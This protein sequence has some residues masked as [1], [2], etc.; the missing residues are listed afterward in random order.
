M[1]PGSRILSTVPDNWYAIMS[2]TSMATPFAV[3]VAALYLSYVRNNN[4]NIKLENNLDYVKVFKEHTLSIKN[5]DI[6]DK[7]FYQGFGILDPK[8]LF[9]SLKSVFFELFF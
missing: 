9:E 6:K 5:S 4:I 1:A 2:G 3:G 8:K 7:C